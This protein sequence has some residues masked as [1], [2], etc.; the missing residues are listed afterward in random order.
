MYTIVIFNFFALIY[1][2]LAYVQ[3]PPLL[4][5]R[6]WQVTDTIEPINYDDYYFADIMKQNGLLL[7]KIHEG[8]FVMLHGP[9]ASGKSTRALDVKKQLY[10]E[11]FFCI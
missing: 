3:A 7:E 8:G 9:R 5:R 11:G 4:R 6:K 2:I 1:F 10:R